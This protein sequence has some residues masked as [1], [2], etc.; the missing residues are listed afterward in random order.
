M[1]GINLFQGERAVVTGAASN[2]GRAVA[3]A[4]ANEGAAVTLVDI[5]AGRMSEVAAEIARGGGTARTIV[6]DLSTNEGW[7]DVFADRD[8]GALEMFVHCACP[9]RHETD[10]VRDVSEET[11]DAMLNTNIRS[12][13]LLA[14]AAGAAMA[15]NGLAGRILFMTSLHAYTPRNLPHYSASKAGMTMLMKEMARQF[16]PSG[17]RVNAIAPGAIPG[18]GFATSD[19]A[20]QPK[21]KIPLGRFGTAEDIAEAAVALLSNRFMKYV[22]GATL[23]VDGGLQLYSWIEPPEG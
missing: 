3:V 16:G 8:A 17:I 15:A 9:R 4:L 19:D 13:F 23:A 21:R 6:C 22:T 18:G 1:S 20:F 14:R 12:G 2:I 7:R 10:I 11:F 5:D